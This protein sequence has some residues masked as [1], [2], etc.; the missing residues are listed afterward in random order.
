MGGDGRTPGRYLAG[1]RWVAR[2]V[3]AR[4]ESY[5]AF[6]RR[7][8]PLL[9]VSPE[10]EIVIE[11]FPRSA[12]TF[13]TV[14]FQ[15]SQPRPVR[16]AH[17]LHAPA[18][19]MAG[20]RMGIP[21]LVPVRHPRDCA[22]SVAIRAPHVSLR[23]A[24]DAHRRFHEA[25]LP[26]RDACLVARFEDVV[27]DFGRVIATVNAR[28][29]TDFTPFAHT[30]ENVDRVYALIDERARQPGHARAIQ[31]FVAGVAPPGRLEAARAGAAA[32]SGGGLPEHR[33][34]RPSPARGDLQARLAERYAEPGMARAREAAEAVY[35]RFAFGG[36]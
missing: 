11:G 24:V 21:V 2:T 25:I 10:T 6:S 31:E 5:L 18:Q 17:H 14:A 9:V 35:R 7:R 8:H 36:E 20:A 32:A 23:E 3:W 28:F 34:A 33:V 26:Y 16:I 15:L 1:R 29:A 19:I 22:I 30:P 13:S 4:H 27:G 12:N